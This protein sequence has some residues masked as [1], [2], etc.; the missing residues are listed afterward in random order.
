MSHDQ[1][2]DA[3]KLMGPKGS[4]GYSSVA[5]EVLLLKFCF[6]GLARVWLDGFIVPVF[7]YVRA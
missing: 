4:G 6:G 7:C 2:T 3:M 5:C 1:R